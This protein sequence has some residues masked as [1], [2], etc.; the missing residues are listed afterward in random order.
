MEAIVGATKLHQ[1]PVHT[2]VYFIE[3]ERTRRDVDISQKR[4]AADTVSMHVWMVSMAVPYDSLDKTGL[5]VQVL[6][7]L[8]LFNAH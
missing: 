8:L 4:S 7:T 6:D 5:M 2:I 1:P 3:P